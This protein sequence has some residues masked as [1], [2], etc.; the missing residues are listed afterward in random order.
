MAGLTDPSS[1]GN[2]SL[3]RLAPVALGHWPDRAKFTDVAA[4]QSKTTHAAPE[5]VS[6]CVS[7][8]I[9]GAG[10]LLVLPDSAAGGCGNNERDFEHCI[11][12]AL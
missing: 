8:A 11:I 9:V 12:S 10:E 7:F 4:R 2:G 1:A 3:M 5:A 6:A